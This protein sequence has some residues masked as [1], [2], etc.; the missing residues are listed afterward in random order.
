M[1]R[2][3][4]LVAIFVSV[5]ILV[6]LVLYADPAK[7]MSIILKSDYRLILAAFIISSFSIFLRITKW[8]VLVGNISFSRIT[9]VQ[10]L[11]MTISNFSPGKLG[12]PVKA[13]ILKL[14][15]N[16]PVSSVMPSI[17]WERILDIVV[18]IGL[19]IIGAYSFIS[20]GA[21]FYLISVIVVIAFSTLLI[22]G[23]LVLYKKR[24]ADFIFR[25]LRRLPVLNRMSE[26]FVKTFQETKVNKQRVIYSF[27][28]TLI[29]WVLEGFVL[30]YSFLS[31]GVT[32]S[33]IMLASMFALATMIGIASSLPGGIGSTDVVMTVFLASF[34]VEKSVAITGI[35]LARFLSIWYLN[36][37]GGLSFIYLTR[38]LNIS[39]RS[40]LR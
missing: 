36:L 17:V 9:P 40:I 19:A 8:K 37:L 21:Q 28:F 31:I 22:I 35:L 25:F 12:E 5:L 33:P 6:L 2:R 11:G 32:L 26:S 7:F 3:L 13:I 20:L 23:L 18:L 14:V 38:K 15:D 30:Y 29:A 39:M 4:K 1:M 16:R 34:G 24:F 27:I 10:L